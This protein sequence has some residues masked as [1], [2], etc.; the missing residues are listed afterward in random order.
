MIWTVGEMGVLPVATA[1]VAD[2]APIEIRGRYQGA[3]GLSF[4]LAVCVAPALGMNVLGALGPAALWLG[5]LGI[6][7]GVAGG[8]LAL[9]RALART[10]AARLAASM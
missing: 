9:A 7:L 4:S 1:L 6:G 3:Y 10:H 8:H 5:C 2:L